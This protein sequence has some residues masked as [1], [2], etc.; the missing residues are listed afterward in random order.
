MRYA[1]T[2]FLGPCNQSPRM[3][4]HISELLK[5][6]DLVAVICYKDSRNRENMT[7]KG[8]HYVF[9]DQFDPTISI[10]LVNIVFKCL[11]LFFMSLWALTQ[12]RYFPDMIIG[13]VF[14]RLNYRFHLLCRLCLY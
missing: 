7:R 3:E 13:Q 11:Y 5:V 1:V 2:F 10:P 9:I 12:L 6:N 14:F 4:N 8:V